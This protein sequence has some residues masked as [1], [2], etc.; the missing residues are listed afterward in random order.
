MKKHLLAL[1]LASLSTS[2]FAVDIE[3]WQYKFDARV[4]TV[5]ALIEKFEKQNPEINVKHVT[6]PYAQ[7]RTKMAAA[8]SA[9]K[10][11]DVLQLYYGWV[12]DYYTSGL[13]QPLSEK[14]ISSKEIDEQFYSFVQGMKYDGQYYAV[15]TAVRTLALFWNKKLFKEAGLTEPPRTLDE[16]VSYSKKLTKRDENNNLLSAGLTVDLA[17]QD[18]HWWREVLIRQMGGVP[19]LNDYQT[20]NYTNEAGEKAFAFMTDLLTKHEVTTPRFM[21]E[22]QAAFK[23]GRAAMHID[24]SFRLSTYNK[25]RRLEWGVAELPSHNGIKSNFSSYWVNAVSKKAQG[26]SRDAAEKFVAFLT[27]EDAMQLWLDNVGELP[28]R[29]AVAER[30]ENV[31]HEQYGPF[32]KGLGYA[33]TTKF[34]SEAS[35]RQTLI[36][37]FDSVVLQGVSVKDALLKASAEEQK[38]LD[39]K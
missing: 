39:K 7:Y 36:N 23:A 16:L 28:A 4:K 20:T 34:K 5:D 15:P 35:Q 2:S 6:F 9:D 38:I 37:A 21:D 24:G 32:I 31:T 8:M 17:E 3:Y 29:R 14:Y 10:G 22:G 12:P 18:H 1:V 25:A 33:H 26:E 11:P 19:Y 27:S 30:P 13:I